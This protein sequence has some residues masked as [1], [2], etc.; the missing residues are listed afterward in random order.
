MRQM[1]I[2]GWNEADADYWKEKG[3]TGNKRPWKNE[4]A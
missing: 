3:W 4:M 1:Q 2:H